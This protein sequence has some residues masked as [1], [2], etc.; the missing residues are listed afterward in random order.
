MSGQDEESRNRYFMRLLDHLCSLPTETEWFEFKVDN[1]DPVQIGE[2]ISALSNSARLHSQERGYLIFGVENNTHKIVGTKFKPKQAKYGSQL[3]ENWLATLL[4]PRID[5]KIHEFEYDGMPIVI[6]EI[7]PTFNTPVKFKG[8]EHIRVGSDKKK[9]SE[10]PE[11]E[12]KIWLIT[13]KTPFEKETALKNVEIDKML[14]LLD[15]KKYYALMKQA[16]PSDPL[17]II[18]KLKEEKLIIE[19]NGNFNI[20]NLGA[21]LLANNLGDFDKLKRKGIRVI[22]YK[23]KNKLDTI[24]EKEGTKGYA[25]GFENLIEYINSILPSNEI[26]GRALR[27]E[28]RVYPEIA[29]RELVANALIHQDFQE[30]G[31]GPMVE[32][33]SDRI[34]I[35]N[36]GKPI[37]ATSRFI[38]H[39]PQSRNEQLAHFMRRVNI[40]EERGSGI[41][42]VIF[43][44]EA[45]QLPAPN[46]VEDEKFLRAIVYSPKS[47]KQMDKDDKI[48]ACYQHCCLRYVSNEVMTNQSLRKRFNIK[49]SNYSVVSRIISD[50]MKNGLI[51]HYD[52]NVTAGRQVK[53]IPFWA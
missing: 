29:I 9:L 34:E 44:I 26:I 11:K 28:V 48:R 42:K 53:Y 4:E 43:S 27:R 49:E 23:G 31:T 46:F 25:V 33:Y 38:D 6:L 45:S 1:V 52:P 2:Y 47:L 39:N 19:Q 21:I 50:T 40:C 13:H 5:F 15:Y 20:T 41:D 8:T 12:R 30:Q 32:I 16:T 24:N 51:K 3:L 7:D 17:A 35:T 36:P 22:I 14:D 10:H 37:I 18:N